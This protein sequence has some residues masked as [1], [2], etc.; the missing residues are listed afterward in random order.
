VCAWEKIG[1]IANC[2]T[3]DGLRTILGGPRLG[4]C[5][6]L[7]LSKHFRI[8]RT[9]GTPFWLGLR[10][11]CRVAALLDSLFFVGSSLGCTSASPEKTECGPC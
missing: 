2:N 5:R 8:S 11:L 3:S 9:C 1:H 10:W 4:E 7:S 6:W